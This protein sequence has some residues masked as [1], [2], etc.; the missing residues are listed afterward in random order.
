MVKTNITYY[1]Y[2][3]LDVKKFS[4]S[5]IHKCASTLTAFILFKVFLDLFWQAKINQGETQH[6]AK[7]TL[8]NNFDLKTCLFT[9]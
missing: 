7:I 3:L 9:R 8:L 4:T 1:Y 6:S 2:H 5:V